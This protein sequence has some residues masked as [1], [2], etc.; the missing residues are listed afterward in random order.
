MDPSQ[1]TTAS[2]AVPGGIP[3]PLATLPFGRKA[4]LLTIFCFAQFLDTFNNS[5]LFTAIPPIA[6]DLSISNSDSVWL[7]SAYQ[8]TFAAFLLTSGRLSDIYNAT[9]VFVSGAALM[10]LLALGAGFV[11]SKVPL[12]V[13]RALM[14]IG[15]ALTVPSALQLIVTMFPDPAEK[16]RA[17]LTFAATTALGNSLIIGAVLVTYASWPWVFYFIAIVSISV[18]ALAL[19]F[20]PRHNNDHY[21]RGKT[22]KR[23][24]PVGIT[25]LTIG[26]ILFVF[27]VTSGS[28]S[29]W[30]SAQVIA[31]LILAV[32]LIFG[33]FIWET[34]VPVDAALPPH[35]W[36]YSNF[37]ILASCGLLP[38]FWWGIIYLE[39]AWL[40][41][42]VYGWSSIVT[43][44]HFLPVCLMG[45]LCVGVAEVL[46]KVL[47]LKYNILLGLAL[48]IGGTAL[49]PL[50]NSEHNYWRFTFPGF[51]IGTT[52]VAITFSAS[53]VA[54]FAVTPPSE[55]GTVG[56]VFNCFLELG[57]AT[58]VA[59]I[60]SIQ[61]TVQEHHGGATAYSGRSAGFWFLFA[62]TCLL[63]VAVAFFMEDSTSVAIVEES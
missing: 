7:L 36:R 42:Q 5:A 23:L 52:G 41:Q 45:T 25:M 15:A 63:G 1:K 59:I 30:R 37:G 57:S 54:I 55:A 43:M 29:G 31:S 58:G 40:W 17:V 39:F 19:F 9:Y 18:A 10:G 56:A 3:S 60:T 27:A 38:F 4:L 12:I 44:V 6:T 53:N 33:F 26:L 46:Q 20:I 2:G 16:S 11:R 8:L 34:R 28:I 14:G 13:L 47:R 22:L 32:A 51:L 49:L 62:F 48:A 24:D 61:T 21:Q 35:M 50:A